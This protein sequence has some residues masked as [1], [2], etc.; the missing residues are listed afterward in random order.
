MNNQDRNL[1]KVY[2]RYSYLAFVLPAAT[3]VGWALGA[4]LDKQFG[5]T[6]LFLVFLL[7]GIAAGII[8]LI[9]ELNKGESGR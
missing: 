9:R 5:T 3:F 2:A 4:W 8:Q 6:Y 1:V 7:F